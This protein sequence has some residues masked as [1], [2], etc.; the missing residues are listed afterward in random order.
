M[1]Q[2]SLGSELS[3]V[4]VDLRGLTSYAGRRSA[5]ATEGRTRQ[6]LMGVDVVLPQDGEVYLFRGLKAGAPLR[7]TVSAEGTS[8]FVRWLLF[9]L[10]LG[11]LIAAAVGVV[12]WRR[13]PQAT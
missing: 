4:G 13:K 9:V 11:A 6:G 5:P 8:P 12:R 1:F 7:V 3:D 2:N 10:C